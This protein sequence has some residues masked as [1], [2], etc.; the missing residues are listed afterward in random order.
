MS[1]KNVNALHRDCLADI[2][3]WKDLDQIA[4][5]WR[6]NA[7]FIPKLSQDERENRLHH[8]RRAVER[9]RNWAE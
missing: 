3:F 1:G 5:Q 8:W 2:G 7:V 6:S 4:A 9:A